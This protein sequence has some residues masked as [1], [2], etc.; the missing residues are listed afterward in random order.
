MPY[1]E[2][3][4]R[5]DENHVE[6]TPIFVTQFQQVLQ[7][8]YEGDESR[9]RATFLGCHRAQTWRCFTMANGHFFRCAVAPQTKARFTV[10][11]QAYQ[12][13]KTDGLDIRDRTNLRKRLKDYAFSRQP[14]GACHYCLGSAGKMVPHHQQ[15]EV[16]TA[17]IG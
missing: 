10:A 15:K 7:Y 8:R 2:I 6:F 1:E 3:Q 13:C 9:V 14:L 16:G 17:D 5:C 4:R 12:G 11:G